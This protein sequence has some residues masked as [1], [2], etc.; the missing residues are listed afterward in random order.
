[1]NNFILLLFIF[2]GF[3]FSAFAA[4]MGV[5]IQLRLKS[6]GG[7][8]PTESGVTV[9]LQVLSVTS[10]CILREET[11][12]NQSVQD[13]AVSVS[14]GSGAKTG[15]DPNL[16]LNQVFD[17]TVSK[18]GLTCVDT[19][20]AVTS[21]SQV[22]TPVAGD[23]RLVRFS[24]TVAGDSIIA[25]F[26]MKSVPYA[27]QAE[28]VGGKTASDLLVRNTLTSLNQT[29]LENLL[30]DNTKL[31]NLQNVADGGAVTSAVSATSATNFT[32]TL[33]GDISGTQSSV[34]VNRIKGIAVSATAP[35]SGQVLQFNG[36]QYV[37][38][39][40]SSAPVSS[41]AGRTGAVVLA[42]GD[43]SGLGTSAV[44]DVGS[45]A[46]N[47]VQLDGAGKIPSSLLPN[48][49]L[50]S[51]STASGDVTGTM[52][53]LTVAT[54]GG[55]T[56]SAIATAVGDVNAATNLN[57]ASKIVK[58][59]GSGNIA[60]NTVSSNNISTQNI[61]IYEATNTNNV[62]IKAPAT[63]SN[64]VLTL[65][66]SGGSA[67]QILSTDGSG[68]LNWV[69]AAG[70]GTVTGVTAGTGLSG[71]TISTS[72]TIALANTAVTAGSYGS[73]TQVGSFTV[74]A[75]GRLTSAGD[76]AIALPPS[77]ITQASA[78]SGQVLKWNGSAWAA[79][80]DTDT[81]S[82]GTVTNVT[83]ANSYLSIATGSSTPVLTLN[84][85]TAANTLAAGDDSR[86]TGALSA[87]TFNGYV[88]SAGC[89]TTQTMYW[90]SVSSTFL[91]QTIGTV[92]NATTAVNFTG[93]VSGDVSGGQ[94]SL[95]V[96]RIKGVPVSATAPTTGQVMVFDG[97]S[98]A[99]AKGF[100]TF[101]KTTSDQTF[102][103]TALANAG[104]SFTVV[105]GA[106]Y[107]YKFNVLYTSAA[108]TTGLRIGLTYP[109]TTMSSALA[110]IPGSTVDGTGFLFSGFISSS[111]DSV[112]SA[113]SPAVSPTVMM[114]NIEGL[115]IP[116]ANGTVQLR[117]SSEVAAS[118]IVIKSGS[119]VEVVELF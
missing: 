42:A 40:M 94:T 22:Y 108:T 53:A 90:N 45:A 72:G 84:I 56:S 71:G 9:K 107:K 50:N 29:N 43:I 35:A 8:Y 80:N 115:I 11:F 4:D 60:V 44:L 20:G 26:P 30:A 104:L 58:R 39:A 25:D 38:V 92:A 59:D 70:S 77:Q 61:Y 19:T 85:G 12:V 13:G 57:T 3:S 55:A 95:V 103:V 49:V 86:I 62:Q 73:S 15:F 21:S 78:S 118:N 79:A 46:N 32:G 7:V 102:S 75:Q 74:D 65:P 119:F 1:M 2:F 33:G 88:A 99:P 117:A 64:Y 81:N 28:S 87:T 114:A 37:P 51:S 24:A 109:A 68:N 5:P 18:S 101:S 67:G 116:S 82:G 105:A 48:S 83:S 10:G 110:N 17:N 113:N 91:C 100:P 69:A 111:G 93:A 97:T 41:V 98:W 34:S 31:S 112:V 76:T 63:F 52:S 54:V 16:T 96:E 66:T 23:H 106:T 47:L 27:V 89:T 14:L 6:P 36:T